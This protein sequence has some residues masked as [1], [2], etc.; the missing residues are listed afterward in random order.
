MNT[1][2]LSLYNPAAASMQSDI[3]FFAGSRRQSGNWNIFNTA[4]SNINY[5]FENK[6]KKKSHNV[7]GFKL[8]NEAEGRYINTNRFYF[9]YS[10][11]TKLNDQLRFAGGISLGLVNYSVV[12]TQR[13][14]NTSEY[15]ID[16]DAG[17]WLQHKKYSLGISTMQIFNNTF[18][19]YQEVLQLER[20]INFSGERSFFINS[21]WKIKAMSTYRLFFQQ[22]QDDIEIYLSQY[23]VNKILFSMGYR[24]NMGMVISL[25]MYQID[26]PP[27]RLRVLISY[28]YPTN[29]DYININSFELSLNYYFNRH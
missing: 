3:E 11:Q 23:I 25:G 9:K 7:I 27:G 22:T 18:Q 29:K 6:K 24:L 12:G 16:S 17:V 14:G 4:Y 26:I 10:W 15:I 21:Q 19:P 13:T 1:E 5:K 8:I 2:S 28:N 20:F